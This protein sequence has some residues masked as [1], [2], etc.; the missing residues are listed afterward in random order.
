MPLDR[1][2][3]TLGILQQ[4]LLKGWLYLHIARE[5]EF[6]HLS[7]GNTNALY[8]FVGVKEACLEYSVLIFNKVA[9]D[10]Q[11]KVSF[12]RLLNEVEQSI[13][14]F[15]SASEDEIRAVIAN[16]EQKLRELRPFIKEVKHWRSNFIAH[17]SLDLVRKPEEMDQHPS[18]NLSHLEESY[19]E[20]FRMMSA[21][22]FQLGVGAVDLELLKGRVQEDFDFLV[23]LIKEADERL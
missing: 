1:L 20:F 8:F 10:N 7:T 16:H 21:Y 12:R 14:E 3:K 11:S 4:T 15:S 2:E 19:R 23:S 9:G 18:L 22:S 6:K 13:N 5:V 17:I